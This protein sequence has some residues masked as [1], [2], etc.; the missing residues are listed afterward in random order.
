MTSVSHASRADEL[1]HIGCRIADRRRTTTKLCVEC[2]YI[3][4]L[5]V[6]VLHELGMLDLL[7]RTVCERLCAHAS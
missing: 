2:V 5:Q 3:K 4:M 7:T 6:A 1:R